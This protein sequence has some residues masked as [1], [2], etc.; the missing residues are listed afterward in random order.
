MNKLVLHQPQLMTFLSGVGSGA[1]NAN[2]TDNHGT[3]TF[4][5]GVKRRLWLRANGQWGENGLRKN[6]YGFGSM[7]VHTYMSQTFVVGGMIEA[8]YLSQEGPAS[9]R[10]GLGA[11]AG[12][13]FLARS[14]NH[15]LFFEG[16]LLHGR[17]SDDVQLSDG[18]KGRPDTR[19]GLAQLRMSGNL[20]YGVT[21]IFPSI[22]ASYVT[23]NA[24]YL[25]HG[26]HAQHGIRLRQVKMGLDFRHTLR[27][28]NGAL[29]VLKGG[30]ALSSSS[31]RTYKSDPWTTLNQRSGSGRLKLGVSY[32]TGAG[33]TVAIDS[34]VDGLGTTSS[35]N[36]G[37][38]AGFDIRF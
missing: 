12:S 18:S 5:S 22:L 11:M 6:A 3:V 34:F 36:Y 25:A 19:R 4:S 2:V 23:E 31:L 37:L 14:T 16:R 21:T 1:L 28:T 15:P 35:Q 13:Y 17:A 30:G 38:K 32:S 9:D 8:D 20:R 29:F 26:P 33:G 24:S 27:R 10:E 7:G